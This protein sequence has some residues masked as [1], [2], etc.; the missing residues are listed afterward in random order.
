MIQ[1][2]ISSKQRLRHIHQHNSTRMW[3]TLKIEC[4]LKIKDRGDKNIWRISVH[5]KRKL[6]FLFSLTKKPSGCDKKES[7]VYNQR[8]Q[9][10]LTKTTI[11]RKELVCKLTSTFCHTSRQRFPLRWFTGSLWDLFDNTTSYIRDLMTCYCACLP[12]LVPA[13]RYTAYML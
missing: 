13:N 4:P 10:R 2:M 7:L 3:W 8:I 12:G 5:S 9:H 11:S 1:G 6:P